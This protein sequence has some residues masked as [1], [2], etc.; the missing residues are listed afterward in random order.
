MHFWLYRILQLGVLLLA[1]GTDSLGNGL[2]EL[3]VGK[4]LGLGPKGNLGAELAP[5][6]HH[7]P[8]RTPGRLVDTNSDWSSQAW[9]R[10][11][12]DPHGLVW[13]EFRPRQGSPQLRIRHWRRKL[14]GP[15]VALD[16]CLRGICGFPL[17]DRPL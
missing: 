11:L 16:L 3:F 17:P 4:I 7:H 10:F 13:C 6:L 12:A 1:A 9:S 2:G 15:F 14:C 5:L 8:S